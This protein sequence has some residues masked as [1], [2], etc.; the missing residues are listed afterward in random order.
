LYLV[1]LISQEIPNSDKSSKM[2][3]SIVGAPPR[4]AVRESAAV[5]AAQSE[6]AFAHFVQQ[7]LFQ[8]C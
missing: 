2:M 7:Q 8:N 5:V 3:F 6:A 1:A 4:E